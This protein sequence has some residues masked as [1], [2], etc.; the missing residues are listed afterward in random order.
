M[1]I[2]TKHLSRTPLLC[3]FMN[4]LYCLIAFLKLI[5]THSEAGTCYVAQAGPELT[6]FLPQTLE[7]PHLAVSC[8]FVFTGDRTN[9]P[10]IG[11]ISLKT[12][13]QVQ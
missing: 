9:L 4:L 12:F 7:S 6:I 2:S 13:G 3:S 10:F 5:Y 1:L 8:C 11:F